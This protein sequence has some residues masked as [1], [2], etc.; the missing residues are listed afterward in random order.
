MNIAVIGGGNGG[1]TILGAFQGIEDFRILGICDVNQNAPGIK[2]AR[3]VGVPTFSDLGDLL[4]QPGLEIIIEATGNERVREQV[5]SLK[6]ARVSLIDSSMANM[7]MTF[8]EGHERLLKRARGKKIAFQTSAPFLVKTYGKDGVIYFTTDTE[9][10]DFVQNHNLDIEGIKVGQSLVQ[11]S[12][13]K[14]CMQSRQE[15]TE[16]IDRSV[17]GIRMRLWVTP[18]YEDDDESKPVIGTY[19]VFTPKL[20]PVAKAF[21]IF[22]PIIIDSQPEGAWVG[23]TDLEKIAYRMGSEK[24]DLKDFKVGTPLTEGDTG[25]L[26]IKARKKIQRDL[27]TK[28]F[29]DIRM[30]GIPLYDEETGDLV[31][32]FGITV[33]RNLARDLLDMANKLNVST[34]EVASVMQEI[35]ASAG[36]INM[37]ESRLAGLIDDVRENTA[38]INE[39]VGFTKSV[40]DQTKMLGL[41]AAIE[42]ARAG[43]HGRGFGV[44]AEEI[45]KLSD[46]SKK[47]AEEISK[48]IKQIDG[49]VQGAVTASENTVK[50]S[51]E[52]AAA[53]QQVTA[54]VMEMTLLA[55]RLIQL[56]KNL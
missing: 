10:Y 54:S 15:I 5:S 42:A 1:T 13:V 3:E 9:R 46:E 40:A 49:S 39:I 52:Q 27:S 11:G 19:G 28:K 7:M 34:S 43:E 51:Q 6:P 37:T 4:R 16:L 30:I 47:T 17:Y 32:T 12:A 21:D 38:S 35:A 2:L 41:N 22:A 33:P 45:R 36:E 55:D 31:G 8:V 48:L 24:F 23:V 20:H 53:T 50:Q 56:A 18:I 14:R 26:T 29:G 44:V 25:S